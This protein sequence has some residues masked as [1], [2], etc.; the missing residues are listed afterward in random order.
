MGSVIPK[1]FLLIDQQP[2][3]FYTIENFFNAFNTIE[4]IVVLPDSHIDY[5]QNICKEYAFNISVKTV[6]GGATRFHSVKEGLQHVS[7]KSIVGIHDGVRPLTSPDLI[8]RCYTLAEEK[9]TAI[10]A[11]LPKDSIR[12][13]SGDTN[14]MVN[15]SDYRLIQTPQCFRSEELLKAYQ[16]DYQEAFTDDA[17]VFENTYPDKINLVEGEYG[18]I[19]ITVE[20]DLKLARV[21]TANTH[22]R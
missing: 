13:V 18:N 21:L 7:R 11:V 10:P 12:K 19:K 17:A 1:Q 6:A 8:R 4:I 20:T 5:W 15:R 9:G 22:P 14:K 2:L 3:L 16:T